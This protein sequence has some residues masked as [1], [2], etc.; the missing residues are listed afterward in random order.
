[1]QRGTG[2]PEPSAGVASGSDI[3][4]L[5][6]AITAR[7]GIGGGSPPPPLELLVPPEAHWT[8]LLSTKMVQL[9]VQSAGRELVSL[10]HGVLGL[11]FG[12][13]CTM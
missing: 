7:P 9:V 10:T 6:D 4:E 8:R 13:H 2:L 5:D 3:C 11:K 1:M 12:R